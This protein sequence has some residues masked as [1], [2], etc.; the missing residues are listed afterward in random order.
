[1]V[2]L[3]VSVDGKVAWPLA[4]VFSVKIWAPILLSNFHEG[5]DSSAEGLGV[6]TRASLQSQT[7]FKK[8]GGDLVVQTNQRL[9]NNG[10][11]LPSYCFFWGQMLI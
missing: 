6:L 10:V 8:V 7:F 3:T 2:N 5:L 11:I 1:M 4:T 9:S